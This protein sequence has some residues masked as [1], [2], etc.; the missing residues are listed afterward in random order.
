MHLIG[1]NRTKTIFLTVC[2]VLWGSHFI[3]KEKWKKNP[4][5][6]IYML[7]MLSVVLQDWRIQ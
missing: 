2:G 4:N 5:Y 6:F 7:I 3:I 1:L